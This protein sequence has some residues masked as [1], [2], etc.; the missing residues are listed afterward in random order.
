MA[1]PLTNENSVIKDYAD[2]RPDGL[3]DYNS[4]SNCPSLRL[5][6]SALNHF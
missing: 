4:F 3:A 2:L 6:V 5:R 1:K